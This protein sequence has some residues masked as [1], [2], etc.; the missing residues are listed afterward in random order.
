MCATDSCGLFVVAPLLESCLL[1]LDVVSCSLL[2]CA[3]ARSFLLSV[4]VAFFLSRR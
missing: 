3:A 4:V 1:P 2:L